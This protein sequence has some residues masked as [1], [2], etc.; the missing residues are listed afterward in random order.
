MKNFTKKIS[1]IIVGITSKDL[2]PLSIQKARQLFLDGIAVAVA[3]SIK[4]EPPSILA[5]HIRSKG[6]ETTAPA[7]TAT[8]V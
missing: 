5:E 4:E 6:A 1:E 2:T 7:A 8:A 3:G